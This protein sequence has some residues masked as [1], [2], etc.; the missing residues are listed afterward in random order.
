VGRRATPAE[1][2][3]L[4]RGR[5]EHFARVAAAVCH[6]AERGRD[7][8][9]NAFVTAVREHR[10]FRGEGPLEAWVWRAVVN[11]ARRGRAKRLRLVA[12]PQ[13]ELAENGTPS[14]HGHV[15]RWLAALPE[16]QRLAVFLR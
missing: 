1:L 4:Y 7:A 16:R 12:V 15:R 2:E 3:S 9:Q 14:E 13:I 8:V 5:F 11:A 10:S 6:D